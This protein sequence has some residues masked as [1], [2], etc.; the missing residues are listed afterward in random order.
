[1]PG[2]YSVTFAA[3]STS[4]QRDAFLAKRRG[5]RAENPDAP[6][7]RVDIIAELWKR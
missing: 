1:M 5:W 2:L 7:A 4:V 3:D 6:I